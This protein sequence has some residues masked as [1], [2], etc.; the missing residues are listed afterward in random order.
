MSIHE[1]LA[2]RLLVAQRRAKL[3][4]QDL[5]AASGVST[6]T[7][8][9]IIAGDANPRLATIERLADALKVEAPWLLG[10]QANPT[11]LDMPNPLRNTEQMI[12]RLRRVVAVDGLSEKN[13][14]SAE[15]ELVK[16]EKLA[17]ALRKQ[18]YDR[19]PD[20]LHL[21]FTLNGDLVR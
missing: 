12:D 11:S 6:S 17:T 10:E 13:R 21:R 16:W 14:K 8:R 2:D 1:T 9:R 19:A 18:G 5:A 7:L 20:V 15:R 4:Q 3:N